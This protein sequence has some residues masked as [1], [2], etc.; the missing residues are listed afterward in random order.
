MAARNI[1]VERFKGQAIVCNAQMKHGQL[2]QYCHISQEGQ[3]L[4]EAA[5]QTKRLS[6]RSYDRIV[7]VARTIADLA[8]SELIEKEHIGE[9]LQLRNDILPQHDR[10]QG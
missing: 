5:F 8:A 7:K 9:A 2:K 1:Q 3:S 4:L 10:F 6:A